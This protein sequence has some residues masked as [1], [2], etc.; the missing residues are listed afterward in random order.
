MW[1]CNTATTGHLQSKAAARLRQLATLKKGTEVV[2]LPPVG[3]NGES[4]RQ[5]K[6][7]AASA[8]AATGSSERSV[9]RMKRLVEQAPELHEKVLATRNVAPVTA[10]RR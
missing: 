8:A 1:Y 4:P 5:A 6:T 2:P 3:G 9:E 10:R 7:A